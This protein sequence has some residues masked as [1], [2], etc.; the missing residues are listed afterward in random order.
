MQYTRT[1]LIEILKQKITKVLDGNPPDAAGC[2]V[3][4]FVANRLLVQKIID[5]VESVERLRTSNLIHGVGIVDV[6]ITESLKKAYACWRAMIRRATSEEY[7]DR[8]GSYRNCAV[9]HEWLVFSNFLKFFNEN[10]IEGYQLDKDILVKGNKRYSADVC[11]FVPA[12]LNGLVVN[13]N[14]KG[15]YFDKSKNRYKATISIRNKQK[16]IASCM[17]EEEAIV[18]YRCAKKKYI[19]EMATEYRAKDMISEKVANALLSR[20]NEL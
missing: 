20:A 16:T 6:E 9:D 18:K 10:Y 3:D 17:T 19:S 1:D 4:V 7:K 12:E 8:K 5:G 14:G 11:C 13:L 15:V 2:V